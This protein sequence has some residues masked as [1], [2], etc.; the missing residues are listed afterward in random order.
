MTEHE[1]LKWICDKIGYDI[2]TYD[3]DIKSFV[4]YMSLNDYRIIKTKEIIFTPEFM[5]KYTYHYCFLKGYC[6]RRLFG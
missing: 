5:E 3:K 1:K 6:L 2:D 4:E